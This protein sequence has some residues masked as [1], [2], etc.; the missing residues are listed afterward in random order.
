MYWSIQ[1]VISRF[2]KKKRKKTYYCSVKGGGGVRGHMWGDVLPH[3][4][5]VDIE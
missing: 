5:S 3:R 1:I 2:K 4:R